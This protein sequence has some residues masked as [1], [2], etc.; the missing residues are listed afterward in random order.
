MFRDS[1][2]RSFIVG[3]VLTKNM[4]WELLAF[5]LI[6]MVDARLMEVQYSLWKLLWHFWGGFG[7]IYKT[8][9]DSLDLCFVFK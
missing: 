1:I 7:I 6:S 4:W 3:L 2:G 9:M 5:P 8:A